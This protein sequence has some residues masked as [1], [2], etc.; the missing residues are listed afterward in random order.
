MPGSMRRRGD[1]WEL[2][3]YAGTDP[4]T[5]KRRW[6]SATTKGTRRAAQRELVELA[7]R[8]NIPRRMTSKATL[9]AGSFTTGTPQCRRTGRRPRLARRRVSS[10]VTSY[11]TSVTFSYRRFAPKTSTPSMV[12]CAD[13]VDT[14]AS[15]CRRAP[16]IEY[17]LCSTGHWPKP[18]AG[19]GSGSIPPVRRRRRRASLHRSI[20]RVPKRSS[21]CCLTCRPPTPSSTP[22][23]RWLSRPGLD[24]ASSVPCTGAKSTSSEVRSDSFERSWMPR[25]VRCCDRPRPAEPTE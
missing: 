24:E 16:C 22:S 23:C 11:R 6:V 13:A 2:R 18:F 14:T 7:A 21:G 25:G 17:M 9:G 1:S 8:V 12:S 5:G 10:I 3:V 4:D 20:P 19:N 15:S